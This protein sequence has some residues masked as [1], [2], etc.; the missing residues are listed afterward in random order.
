MAS[1]SQVDGISVEDIVI[2][3][4]E[5]GRN[6]KIPFV[7]D[8]IVPHPT[9]DFLSREDHK[10]VPFIFRNLSCICESSMAFIVHISRRFVHKL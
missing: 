7:F 1:K 10:A 2:G 4:V 3:P 8:V 9:Q 5:K 6:Y